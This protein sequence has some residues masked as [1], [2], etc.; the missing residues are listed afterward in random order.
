VSSQAA[1]VMMQLLAFAAAFS[2]QDQQPFSTGGLDP[3]S[4]FQPKDPAGASAPPRLDPKAGKARPTPSINSISTRKSRTKPA[5]RSSSRR[6][7]ADV[8]SS[9]LVPLL[10]PSAQVK[11]PATW[12]WHAGCRTGAYAGVKRTSVGVC[13]C[14]LY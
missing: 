2:L 11:R 4:T 8:T 7:P 12:H 1:C 6:L 13:C 3:L 14:W 5:E 10:L 9:G